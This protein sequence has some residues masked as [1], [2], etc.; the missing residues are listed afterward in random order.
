MLI[1]S[2]VNTVQITREHFCLLFVYKKTAIYIFRGFLRPCKKCRKMF[3]EGNAVHPVGYDSLL[4]IVMAVWR[5]FFEFVLAGLG[6]TA[7]CK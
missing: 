5:T 1:F 4:Q 2:K 3:S 6:V 7:L